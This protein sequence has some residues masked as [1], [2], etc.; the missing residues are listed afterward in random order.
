MK[1]HLS[2]QMKQRLSRSQVQLLARRWF[3]TVRLFSD[4]CAQELLEGID[5]ANCPIIGAA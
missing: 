2:S 1:L 3:P 5:A 4:A